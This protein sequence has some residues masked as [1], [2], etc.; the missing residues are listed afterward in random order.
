MVTKEWVADPPQAPRQ[1]RDRRG[2]AQPADARHQE[3]VL[4]GRRALPRRGRRTRRRWRSTATARPTTGSSAISTR[5]YSWQGI[6]LMLAI[7]LVLFGPIGADHLGGAD[8]VDPG[9]RRRHH[10]RHRPLLGLP[11]LR[12]RRRQHQ[13]RALGHPDR[14]RGAAQQPPRLRH[15][16]QASR[17]AGTSS[18]SA[19]CTSASWKRWAWPRCAR[20]RRRCTSQ[21]RRSRVRPETLQAM[22]THR[23]DVM[24]RTRGALRADLRRRDR[25]AAQSA[26]RRVAGRC[27]PGAPE[28][29]AV[30]RVRPTR[31][32]PTRRDA[33]RGAGARARRCRRSIAMRQDLAASG[34]RST[35]TREQLLEHLQ[36]W[37]QR[38]EA[39]GIA[40][41]AGV[42]AC[43]C[44]ATPDR[45]GEGALADCERR[46][47]SAAIRR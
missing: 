7:N 21:P 18:T 2:S 20:S 6:G 23:Y 41:L 28:A 16:G 45:P 22:I 12:L 5:R 44:A 39:V 27:E 25:A 29:L 1:V 46:R 34:A 37:C 19:G 33:R 42:L 9:L 10:Q 11:Q 24:P 32:R 13:H 8:A 40:S 38:A 47:R 36:D 35:A 17:R 31:C 4:A 43:G 3:S 26:A 15:L 14:R 30:R